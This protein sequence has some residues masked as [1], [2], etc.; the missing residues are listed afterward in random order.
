MTDIGVYTLPETL[1]RKIEHA[2][3]ENYIVWWDLFIR[4]EPL[5]EK[6]YFA[7][8]GRW[9]GYFTIKNIVPFDQGVR[10]FLEDWHEIDIEN[11]RPPFQ[12]FTYRTPEVV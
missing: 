7:S 5:P 4:P 9:Q 6:V 3:E 2:A 11:N 10:M 12:G 8:S 1:E